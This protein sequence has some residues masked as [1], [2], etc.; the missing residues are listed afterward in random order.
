V[1]SANDG[2]EEQFVPDMFS[3]AAVGL[4]LRFAENWFAWN[5]EE[6]RGRRYEAADELALIARERTASIRRYPICSFD[7]LPSLG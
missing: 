4:E 2:F 1:R 7:P 3:Q 6:I 5:H